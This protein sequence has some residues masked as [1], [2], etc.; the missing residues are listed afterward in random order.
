[1]ADAGPQRSR[2]TW[3]FLV[4]AGV[5]AAAIAVALVLALGG[6]DSEAQTVTFQPPTEAGRDPFTRPADR[7]GRRTVRLPASAQGPFGGTGSDLVCDRELL[8]RAL[9]ARP[10]RLRVWAAIAGVEPTARAV[11]RYIR[12]LRPVTLVRD[13]RV[14]NHSFTDGRAVA[15]Q[16]IL[17][18]G[19]AVLVDSSGRPVARCR[20]GNPLLEPV[21]I[22]TARCLACPAGYTPPPPCPD[23]RECYRRYPDP[24]PVRTA[25]TPTPTPTPPPPPDQPGD[26][27]CDPA[28]SQ[29]EFERCRD[30]GLLP[31]QQQ[32]PD[33][34]QGPTDY[35]DAAARF[36]PESGSP[37]DVYTLSVSGFQPDA[38]LA[39]VL[40]RPDGASE[41]YTIA[42][43]STGQGSYTF[44]RTEPAMPGT[45]TAR[46]SRDG[47]EATATT[48]VTE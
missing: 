20:C 22:A 23:Y 21:Y 32:G 30:A 45:Y 36:S 10:D 19:T 26:L 18:A 46:V 15:Y 31:E 35:I 25:R 2:P 13:T 24:P 6:E 3:P 7:R 47:V 28:R 12:R 11:A 8:V 1:M 5:I 16:S 48:T 14:T 34:P 33:D 42:T 27:Q 4:L 44:P 38:R 40:T 39:V 43:D 29:L 41:S 37:D 9:R 17:A